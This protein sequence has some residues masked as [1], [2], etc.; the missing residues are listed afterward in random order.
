MHAPQEN[1]EKGYKIV[2]SESHFEEFFFSNKMFDGYCDESG[3]HPSSVYPT[4]RFGEYCDEPGIRPRLSIRANK[5][6][7]RGLVFGCFQCIL[8]GIYSVDT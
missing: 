5:L 1:F 3:A 8:N 7:P 4:V 2:H 6:V